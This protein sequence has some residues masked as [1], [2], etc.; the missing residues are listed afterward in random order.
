MSAAAAAPNANANANVEGETT[1]RAGRL[2]LGSNDNATVNDA[3][4]CLMACSLPSGSCSYRCIF[5]E[6]S[7]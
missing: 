2:I 6:V 4:R 5:V 3:P 1:D 7:R